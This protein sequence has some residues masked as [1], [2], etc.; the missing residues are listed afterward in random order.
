MDLNSVS[1]AELKN[2]Q[3]DVAAAITN[4]EDLVKS[5]AR[6]EPVGVDPP[7][8]RTPSFRKV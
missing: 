1:L 3:K 8:K 2:L 5:K 4:F 6:A 7:R